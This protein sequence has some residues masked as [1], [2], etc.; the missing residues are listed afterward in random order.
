MSETRLGSVP[1]AG[2]RALEVVLHDLLRE[3]TG[4]R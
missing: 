1:F 4:Q 2:G 3:K